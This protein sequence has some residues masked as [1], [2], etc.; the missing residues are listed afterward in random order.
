MKPESFQ[1]ALVT[2]AVAAA[3]AGGVMSVQAASHREAPITALDRT[4]DITD[5]FAFRGYEKGKEDT[6]TMILNVDPLL[7]PSN[8][9][10]YFP[11]DDEVVY[12]M[13]L[14][15]NRDGIDD[16]VWEFRFTTEVRLDG[17]F[18]A[19]VGAGHGI[20][21]PANAPTD[22]NGNPTAG[23]PLIPPAMT[24]LDNAGSEGLNLRQTYTMTVFDGQGAVLAGPFSTDAS[25]A[26]LIAVPSNVG[27]RTMPNYPALARQ[28][29]FALEGGARLFAG[30]VDDPFYID[31]ARPSTPS[32]YPWRHSPE[33]RIVMTT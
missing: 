2:A 32:T 10:N 3:C 27:P 12:K 33:D 13:N 14:D 23:A 25:G 31:W 8:G 9:P 22:I 29:V 7:E 24:A 19:F 18:T 28:G 17:V 21:A 1:R 30:T 20:A 16:I 15:N 5:W 6:F 26:P 4:A 11:F